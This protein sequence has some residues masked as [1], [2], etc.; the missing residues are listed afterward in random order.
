MTLSEYGQINEDA[1]FDV[2]E[3]QGTLLA[4]QETAFSS[5]RLYEVAGFYVEVH[6]HHHF[7]VI[8]K[9]EAFATTD[10]LDHWLEGISIDGL[11]H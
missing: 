5:V 11:F 2:L 8:T 10:K 4:E 6:H 9:L 1:Q 3:R 7:N